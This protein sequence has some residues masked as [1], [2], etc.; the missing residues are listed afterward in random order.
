MLYGQPKT[1]LAPMTTHNIE[2]TS[3]V[4]ILAGDE[5]DPRINFEVRVELVGETRQFPLA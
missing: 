3:E 1:T 5:L 4:A 2:A